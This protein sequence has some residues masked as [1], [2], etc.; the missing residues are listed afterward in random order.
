MRRV[1]LMQKLRTRYAL[2]TRAFRYD[3]RAKEI[4]ATVHYTYDTDCKCDEMKPNK[5][6]E[7][8]LVL[9]PVSNFD[10]T[11]PYFSRQATTTGRMPDILL[12]L[13]QS[14]FKR[15]TKL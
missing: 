10:I 11:F 2:H 7:F 14:P 15:L 12:R 13:E 5:L 9:S 6:N 1:S 3:G 8:C 4:Y